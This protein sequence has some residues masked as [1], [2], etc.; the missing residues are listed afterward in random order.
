MEAQCELYGRVGHAC[1]TCAAA[2]TLT[3]TTFGQAT[4]LVLLVLRLL[5]PLV[6]LQL[7]VAMYSRRRCIYSIVL[8]HYVIT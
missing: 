4:K 2:V 3:M 7:Q 1:M 5:V 8:G 6:P